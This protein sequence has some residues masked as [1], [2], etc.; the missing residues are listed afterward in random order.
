ALQGTPRMWEYCVQYRESDFDFVSRLMEQ[1]GIYY[2]FEHA[3][4]KHTLVL[5]DAPSCHRLMS[6]DS[7]WPYRGAGDGRIGQDHVEEWQCRHEV[8]TGAYV[9]QDYDF[10][11][12]NAGLETR[13]QVSRSHALASYE[14]Y[15]YPG[16]YVKA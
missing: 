5:V 3:A 4:D 11:A 16:E 6:G 15:D 9:L 8:Q 12:P 7:E 1:D 2:Y 10:L 13:S 14:Q